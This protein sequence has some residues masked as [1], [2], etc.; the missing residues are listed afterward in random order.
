MYPATQPRE[1]AYSCH[2]FSGAEELGTIDAPE[3]PSVVAMSIAPF[4]LRSKNG[5][6]ILAPFD[7]T[8]ASFGSMPDALSA[9]AYSQD[10]DGRPP[11][12]CAPIHRSLSASE[13]IV[14]SSGMFQ[15]FET[16]YDC[17]SVRKTKR[18]FRR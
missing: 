15:S 16:H 11:S 5:M 7:R 8:T 6:T 1:A 9:R 12:W 10:W 18:D 3:R 2:S 4:Q 17:M 13:R 14:T